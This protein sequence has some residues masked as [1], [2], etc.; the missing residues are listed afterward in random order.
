VRKNIDWRLRGYDAEPYTWEVK[1]AG[2]PI[3]MLH[4]RSPKYRDLASIGRARVLKI[5]TLE[6]IRRPGAD[7]NSN[8]PVLDGTLSAGGCP[9][10][11]K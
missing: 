8:N 7:E 4:C 2:N 10:A 9:R 5:Y 1:G 6:K 11:G 3:C